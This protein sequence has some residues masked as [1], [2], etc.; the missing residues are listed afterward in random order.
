MIT[1]PADARFLLNVPLKP[2]QGARFQPTGF[3]DLGPATFDRPRGDGTVTMLMVESPQSVANRLE[4]VCLD[5]TGALAAELEGLPYVQVEEDGEPLTNSLQEAHRLNSPYIEHGVYQGNKNGFHKLLAEE[6]GYDPKRPFSF[7]RLAKVIFKYDPNALIHGCFLESIAGVLR[8]PRM[9]SGFIEAENVRSVAYGG[10]K[11]DRVMP[12]TKDA[13]VSAKEGYGNV[14]YHREDFAAESIMAY[15]NV[16]LTQLR[17]YGLGEE[18]ERLLFALS[19]W[20]V[21][22]FLATGLRLRTACDLGV[23]DES[24]VPL[25][26]ESE[27]GS[28]LPALI[29]ACREQFADPRVTVLQRG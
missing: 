4:S 22:Q 7:Q 12:S 20:K 21:R 2:L 18:A 29:S 9:L 24:S 23:E 19:A 1:V 6:I 11:N 8:V 13:N 25:P 28:A 10:V 16:D 14:P 3:P 15:F 27:L 5:P 17:S 26:T